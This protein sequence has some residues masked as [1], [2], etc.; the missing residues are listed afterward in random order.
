[1]QYRLVMKIAK[2]KYQPFDLQELNKNISAEELMTLQ[3]ID[4]FTSY[5]PDEMSL[6]NDLLEANFISVDELDNDLK[7][8]F[9]ENGNYREYKYGIWYQN[10]IDYFDAK[11]IINFILDNQSN[12][13]V[14]N[15]LYNEFIHRQDK[16]AYWFYILNVLRNIREASNKKDIHYIEYLPYEE[17]RSLGTYI[18]QNFCDTINL[19]RNDKNGIQ[20][21]RSADQIRND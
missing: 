5:Y 21:I 11:F 18:Y 15:K 20:K 1:M 9:Y 12:Y 13:K 16:S 4:R 8:I 10:K 3:G 7:I 6:K 2:N 19:D 14:L 17:R